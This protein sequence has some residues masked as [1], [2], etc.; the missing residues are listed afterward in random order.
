MSSGFMVG[1]VAL[2]P[3]EGLI[4]HLE[5]AILEYKNNP[6]KKN[7]QHLGA[8]CVFV[9]LKERSVSEGSGDEISDALKI[10]EKFDKHINW[11]KME[12]DKNKS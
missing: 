7:F 11:M 3:T 9:G 2:M 5:E 10:S 6:S 4:K 1:L 12:P 8:C